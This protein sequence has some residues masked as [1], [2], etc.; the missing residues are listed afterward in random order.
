MIGGVFQPNDAGG[1]INDT[2]E[3]MG[4]F[5]AFKKTVDGLLEKG[6]KAQAMQLLQ[7]RSKEYAG[8]TVAGAFT[9]KMGQLSKA[10]TAIR[11]SN[12]SPEE[13]RRM[14]DNIRQ[15]KIQTAAAFREAY[16]K[17]KGE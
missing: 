11:A 5:T 3:K 16:G 17:I 8:A 9:Q 4:E 12:R 13:K 15:Y 6:E 2:Y 1:I 7:E 14:L 10:E